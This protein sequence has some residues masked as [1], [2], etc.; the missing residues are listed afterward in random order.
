MGF[1]VQDFDTADDVPAASGTV[2]VVRLEVRLC[3]GRS[4][5]GFAQHL[6]RSV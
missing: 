6:D 5:L 1:R 2:E 3:T 4:R